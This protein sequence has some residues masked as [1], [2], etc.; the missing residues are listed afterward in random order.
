MGSQTLHLHVA[1]GHEW[2]QQQEAALLYD[3]DLVLVLHRQVRE[4]ARGLLL[5]FRIACMH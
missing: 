1:L 4:A 2:D 5:R 3:R